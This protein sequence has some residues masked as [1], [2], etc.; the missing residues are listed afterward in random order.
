LSRL[1]PIQLSRKLVKYLGSKKKVS[2][3][4]FYNSKRWT[5][6]KVQGLNL[7]WIFQKWTV[8]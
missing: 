4:R 2:R 3:V 5:Y 7:T 1:K 6:S 8:L